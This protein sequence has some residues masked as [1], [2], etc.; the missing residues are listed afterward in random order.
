MKKIK[1]LCYCDSPT[2][3]T[4]FGTVS[5][6]VLAQLYATGRYEI[7]IF[8][9][10]HHGDPYDFP[11]RIWPASDYQAGD[12]YGRRKFCYFAMQ[13]DF[14]IL[15]VLQDTF[16][17]DFLPELIKHL[18]SNRAKPFRTIMY[19]P[20][21][22]ILREEWC[23]NL[24]DVDKLV[25][26]TEFGKQ[27]LLKHLPNKQDVDVIYHGVD[28]KVFKPLS[29]E[30]INSFRASYFSHGKDRFIFMNVNRN[31]QRKD[32]PRTILAFKEFKKVVPESMLYLHTAPVDQGWNIPKLLEAM[33][34]K[35]GKDV[36]LPE[37]MEPN[38]GYPVEVVNYLYNSVDCVVSTTLGE[39]MGLCLHYDT[40]IYTDTGIKYIKDLTVS[41]KVLSSDGTYNAVEGIMT[42][43]HDGDLYSI[44]TWMT[45][46]PVKS[47]AEHG[48]KVMTDKGCV[49]KKASELSIG[50]Y[51]VFPKS[52]STKDTGNTIDV[53]SFIKPYLNKAH[54]NNLVETS[55]HF[56]IQSNFTKESKFIPKT[57]KVT[58]DLMFLLGLFLAEGHV[59]ASKM[60]SI[61]FS[62]HKDETH[63]INFVNKSMLEIFGLESH[64][65]N[66]RSRRNY[67]GQ[68]IIFYS[69]VVAFLF[70]S[71]FGL[72]ARNKFIHK[73]ILNQSPEL[74]KELLLGEFL[75]DGSYSK[76]TY[77]FSISTTSK[78]IAYSLR[79]IMARLNILSSV[80]TSRVEYKVNVSGTSK[81]KL[82]DMFNIVYD[83]T[84]KW[85]NGYD[86]AIQNDDYLL[87]PIKQISKEHY[88]GKLVDIQV[89]NTNDFV[90]E[91]VVVHNSWLEAMACKIPVIMPNNTSMKELISEDLGYLADSGSSS[92]LWT[93][94]PNDNDVLRPLVDVDDLV[95]KMC[96]VYDN[97]DEAL[98]K[99][100]NAFDWA[101]NNMTWSG[102]IAKQWVAVFD[103]EAAQLSK[104]NKNTKNIKLEQL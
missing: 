87:Y 40:N 41:D 31:Q 93:S 18:K 102:N 38:Q 59:G 4:G 75:G 35:L 53:L 49:W 37:K 69:S 92:S 86:R 63:L 103:N 67:N 97:Y 16:I 47:S 34:I 72:G 50:D 36:V 98:T 77:E 30:E 12:P 85:E 60:D 83:K 1:I 71:L 13:H 81:R 90:A 101:Q 58:K 99:S 28:N 15:W 19:F 84:R 46:T 68:S 82:L 43:K 5:R 96:H 7:D 104:V 23:K 11:Y 56:K 51:L 95:K 94:L 70:K 29:A 10:N 8:G 89:A 22:S 9:I 24:A 21:D 17:V 78:H 32:L 64:P 100:I 44:T 76:S 26:Y 66:H 65:V 61:G 42:K 52:N 57:L 80:R 3:A 91:N 54:L 14:D 27:A 74:L 48:F 39:G 88:K 2:V 25:A 79:L 33:D 6:N 45:N 62:F 73:H 55:T 20:V